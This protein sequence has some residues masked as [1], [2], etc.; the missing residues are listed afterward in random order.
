MRSRRRADARVAAL[1]Q[2]PSPSPSR[3]SRGDVRAR[4]AG[5]WCATSARRPASRAPAWTRRWRSTA[6][7][8]GEIEPA[9]A[10]TQIR[11][12]L[13]DAYQARLAD[14]LDEAASELERGFGPRGG[15]VGRARARLLADPRAR[16]RGAARRRRAPKRRP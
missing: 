9:E 1:R 5:S 3:R 10:V 2:G 14:Y 12:D 16:V 8:A 11:K 6:L 7:A 13:L 4:A 15:R